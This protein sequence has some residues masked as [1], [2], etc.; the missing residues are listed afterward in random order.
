MASLRSPGNVLGSPGD[1]TKPL[2]TPTAV[3]TT[4]TCRFIKRVNAKY[5]LS[6][7]TYFDL[8][9]WSTT[10]IDDFWSEVWDEAGTIGYKGEH[11]VDASALPPANPPWFTDAKV[12]WAENMLRCRSQKTAIIEA[13]KSSATSVLC[14]RLVRVIV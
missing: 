3:E 9:S 7:E 11:V 13:S 6:L 4:R 5:G 14:K 12:N 2:Y 10:R 8:W 1:D